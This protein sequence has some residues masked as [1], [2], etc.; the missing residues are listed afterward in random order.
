[1]AETACFPARLLIEVDHQKKVNLGVLRGAD[2]DGPDKVLP[3]STVDGVS[4]EFKVT[5]ELW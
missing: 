3:F 1:M 4:V 5:L 2:H